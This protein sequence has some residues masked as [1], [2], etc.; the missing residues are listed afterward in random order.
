TL[1]LAP[2]VLVMSQIQGTAMAHHDVVVE[3]AAKSLPQFERVIVDR[4]A[5]VEEVV[6]ADD[7]R[8]PPGI[9][10]ADPALLHHRDIG[11]PML[12]GEV[13]G[14]GEAMPAAANDH[15]LVKGLGLRAAPGA[16]PAG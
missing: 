13:V 11:Q 2:L 15:R 3:L 10:A 14:S 5:L 12:P 1:E 4:R 8:V 9:A 6:G 16:P 7:R